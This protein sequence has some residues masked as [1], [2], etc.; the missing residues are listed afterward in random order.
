MI[1][2]LALVEELKHAL[3][4]PWARVHTKSVGFGAIEK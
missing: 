3:V 1:L 4:L 2:Q